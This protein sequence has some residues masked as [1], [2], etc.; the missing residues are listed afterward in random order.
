MPERGRLDE[1]RLALAGGMA[2]A[3]GVGLLGAGNMALGGWGGGMMSLMGS[4]YVGYGATVPGV[5]TGM[6]W[7]LA[8][9]G[10]C[11]YVLAW[12]YNRA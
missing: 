8:D 2:W 4:V 5:L 10:I 6:V 7:A 12:L 9:G 3:L 1:R 11:G